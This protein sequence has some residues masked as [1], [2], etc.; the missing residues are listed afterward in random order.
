MELISDNA[1]KEKEDDHFGFSPLVEILRKAIVDSKSL[2]FTIGVF[3][4]WGCGK[5]SFLQLLRGSLESADCKTV[6]FNPWKYDN[7]EELWASLIHTILLGIH[8]DPKIKKEVRN[9]AWEVLRE[10]AWFLFKKGVSTATNNFITTDDIEGAR[11]RIAA[12]SASDHEFL[13]KFEEKFSSLVSE[14]VG[15]N[16]KLVVFIDDLDRCIPE[17]AITILES[18]K[19]YLDNSA[20]V[21]VIAMD[22]AIVELGIRHRYGKDIDMSGREYLE[23]MIQL[24]FFLPPVQFGKLQDLLKAKTKTSDY[25]KEIWTLLAYG[26]GGNPRKTKRFVNSFYM[27]QQ[28]LQRPEALGD[29]IPIK[30]DPWDA[31]LPGLENNKKQDQLFYL[32]KVLVI[33]MSHTDFYDYLLFNPAGW[34]MYERILLEGESQEGLKNKEKIFHDDSKF[35]RLWENRHLRFFMTRTSGTGF[36]DPPSELILERTLK[37]TGIVD[38]SRRREKDPW[39]ESEEFN[40]DEGKFNPQQKQTAL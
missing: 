32:A 27:A 37:F 28:A 30:G 33:Q 18:L 11:D 39:A 25:T 23:K 17:N 1:I 31:G 13:N 12:Q 29:I 38:G 22:R 15:E 4:E 35:S 34:D 20:C 6:W 21:F 16:G 10:T 24:P 9:K 26:L 2:P 19:L 5:T 3:G 8:S 14:F 40:P 36:P 7:K